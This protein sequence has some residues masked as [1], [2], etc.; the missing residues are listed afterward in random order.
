MRL[1]S[2]SI[3]ITAASLDAEAFEDPPPFFDHA[4]LD[5]AEVSADALSRLF[6]DASLSSTVVFPSELSFSA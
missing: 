2:S 4:S 6:F 5:L 3:L 1:S